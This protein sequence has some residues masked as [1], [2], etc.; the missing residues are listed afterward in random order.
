[1]LSF[2]VVSLHPAEYL[3]IAAEVTI[4]PG[5]D[6]KGPRHINRIEYIHPTSNDIISPADIRL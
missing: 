5:K 6:L 2:L 3:S 4:G 1:M